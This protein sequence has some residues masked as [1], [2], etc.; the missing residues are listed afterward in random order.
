MIDLVYGIISL[1]LVC[2]YSSASS[3]CH[4]L[5]VETTDEPEPQHFESVAEFST[6]FC[7]VHEERKASHAKIEEDDLT[8]EVKVVVEAVPVHFQ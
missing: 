7:T 2:R 6:P 3:T 4:N 5:C 1:F 8:R